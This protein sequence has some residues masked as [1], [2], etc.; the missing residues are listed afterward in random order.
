[1]SAAPGVGNGRLDQPEVERVVVGADHPAP[2]Q[3]IGVVAQAGPAR[4]HDLRRGGRRVRGYGQDLGGVEPADLDDDVLARG[5]PANVGEKGLVLFV[6]DQG[7]GALVAAH[8]VPVHR[9]A[10]QELGILLDVEDSPAVVGPDDG[11]EHTL[12]RLLKDL[13]ARQILEAQRAHSTPDGI[14]G[15]GEPLAIRAHCDLAGAVVR[16]AGRSRR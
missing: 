4:K 10:L 14:L 9:A 11:F 8:D 5:A 1:M 12:D 15:P 16:L 6:V 2:A 3:M 13:A 7:I